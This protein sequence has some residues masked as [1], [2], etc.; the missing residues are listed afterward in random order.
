MSKEFNNDKGITKDMM[1]EKTQWKIKEVMTWHGWRFDM[2]DK[3]GN[4]YDGVLMS[5]EV[6]VTLW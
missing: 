4:T 6:I 2:C 3:V 5:H 1:A